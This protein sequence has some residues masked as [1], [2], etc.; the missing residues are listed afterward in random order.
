M[1]FFMSSL[2]CLAIL[3]QANNVQATPDK[4]QMSIYEAINKAG[5]QRML[6]QRIAKCY[7]AIVCNIDPDRYRTHLNGSAKLFENNLAELQEFA[8]NDEIRNQY[9]YVSILWRNY[10]FIYSDEF[11]E[12]NALTILRFNDK[13]LKACH[14]AVMMLEKHVEEINAEANADSKRKKVKNPLDAELSSIVNVSGR[15]RM[16]SQ[17]F[18]LYLIA[19]L[20][21][22]GE[23][24]PVAANLETAELD[25]EAALSQLIGFEKNTSDIQAE[26]K[27]IQERWEDLSTQVAS[28]NV[29][30]M[31]IVAKQEGAQK[32]MYMT[33]EILFSFDEVV[34]LYER[35]GTEGN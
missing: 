33:E 14:E 22:I 10:K 20:Y 13:I 6:T 8:P 27:K 17:R 29:S 3:V 28:M 34:F 32:V 19:Q 5:Y 15:Q 16:L 2:L 18:S 4:V 12:E 21:K 7:M 35:L 25:F 30:D 26:L 1:R 31:S 23:Q 9:R 11:T 24:T